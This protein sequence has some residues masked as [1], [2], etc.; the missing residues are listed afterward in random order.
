MAIGDGGGWKNRAGTENGN[1]WGNLWDQ[2]VT[3][4]WEAT[5]VYGDVPG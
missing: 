3:W 2:V 4:D 1:Q 5:A